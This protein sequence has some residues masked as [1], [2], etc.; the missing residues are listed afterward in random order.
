MTQ[1][2]NQRLTRVI[3]QRRLKEKLEHDL[4]AVEEELQSEFPKLESLSLKLEEEK[5][6]V[7]KLEQTSLTGLLFSVLGTREQ[8]LEKERQELLKRR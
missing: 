6:D 7:E 5:V 8:Q 4:R 3:E 2:L 1:E